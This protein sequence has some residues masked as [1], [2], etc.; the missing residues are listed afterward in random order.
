MA[1]MTFDNDDDDDDNF[2]SEFA[3]GWAVKFFLSCEKK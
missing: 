1:T 2:K 3:Y